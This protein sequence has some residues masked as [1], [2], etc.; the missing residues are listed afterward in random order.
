MRV[1][2]EALA[3][4]IVV[5][6]VRVGANPFSWEVHRAGTTAPVQVSTEGF[7][8]MEAAYQAGK[9][10]LAAFITKRLPPSLET[11]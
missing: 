1:S 10:C 5:R 8:S 6:R 2:K 4:S 9:A 3:L 7:R 11:T